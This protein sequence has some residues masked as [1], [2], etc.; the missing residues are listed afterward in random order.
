MKSKICFCILF[1]IINTVC[2][3]QTPVVLITNYNPNGTETILSGNDIQTG[4]EIHDF[5]KSVLQVDPQKYIATLEFDGTDWLDEGETN[6]PMS[7]RYNTAQDANSDGEIDTED[8]LENYVRFTIGDSIYGTGRTG[9]ANRGP[10]DQR[11]S[12]YFHFI[13]TPHYDV[14]EYWLYYPDNDWLN[15]HEHDWEKYYVY[16]QDTTPFYVCISS[17]ISFTGYSWCEILHDNN[18]SLIGV[19]GG[20]HGMKTGSE[21]GVKIRYNGEISENNGTLIYGDSLTI[22]WIIYSNAPNVL[23]AVPYIQSPDTFYYGD[24]YYIT[25]SNEYGDPN[26]SPWIRTEWDN[27][28]SVPVT[29]LGADTVICNGNSIVIDAG[30]GFSSYHWSSGSVSQSITV[31]ATGI[32]YVEVTDSYGCVNTDTINVYVNPSVFVNLGNDTTIYVGDSYSLNAGSGFISYL[33]NDG[34]VNQTLIVD[35]SA[36]GIGTH[37]YYVSTTD[38]IGC[39]YS[40]SIYVTI[41]L[42]TSSEFSDNNPHV[43]IYPNPS[44]EVFYFDF[45]DKEQSIE[46]KVYNAFGR[47]I[48]SEKISTVRIYSL[49]LSSQESGI[50]YIYL[51]KDTLADVFKISVIK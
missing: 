25:N 41:T 11:P 36:A 26:L 7:Y 49:D 14:Y 31:N 45:F 28:P 33:W 46:V 13:R 48:K 15:D 38:S 10:N 32:Y 5:G 23:G 42:N 2:F 43:I 3:A 8:N 4:T 21:D 22:P 9:L 6:Y 37:L 51:I 35:A 34:S 39:T 30:S 44:K 17:H 18:H 47:F 20:S 16:V 50:Y 19:D 40:D 1:I 12:L 27:P 24:P 29:D